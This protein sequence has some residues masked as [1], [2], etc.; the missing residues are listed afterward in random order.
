MDPLITFIVPCHNSGKY[1]GDCLTSIFGQP[2]IVEFEVLVIDDASTDNTHEIARMFSDHRTR[3]IRHTTKQGPTRTF[4]EAIKEA[5]GNFIARI[6]PRD[7]YRPNFL[8]TTLQILRDNAEC[9]VAYGDVALMNEQ[10]QFTQSRSDQEHNGRDFKGNE[11]LRLLQ[12]NFISGSTVLGR[13]E[14]WRKAL[15]LPEGLSFPEWYC[16]IQMARHT[17]FYYVNQAVADHRVADAPPVSH[18]KVEETS[19]FWILNQVFN[20]TEVNYELQRAKQKARSK[21]YALQYRSFGDRYL[22]SGMYS[23]ARRCYFRALTAHP[24]SIK[25]DMLRRMYV[26]FSGAKSGSSFP[27]R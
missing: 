11:F 7:R 10:G 15:P 14:A 2:L 17:D 18:L 23:D 27:I 9:A 26:A 1:L 25:I 21:I 16:A 24:L 13:T 12:R 6:D 19:V 3:L 5:R 22:A 4:N 20:Q 8:I